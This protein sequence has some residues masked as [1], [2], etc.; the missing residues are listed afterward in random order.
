MAKRST[1]PA[2]D[3]SIPL[4]AP[5]EEPVAVHPITTLD[6]VIGQTNALKNLRT[7]MH[8]GRIHH[9][10]IFHGPAGVGKFTTAVAFAAAILDPTTSPDLSGNLGPED[11]SHVQRLVRAG[12]HP[13]LHVVRKELAGISRNPQVRD[14]KQSGIAKDVVEEFLTEPA[15]RSRVMPGDSRAAKVFVIDEAELLSPISQNTLLKT[16]EEPPPGT[17]IILITSAEERLLPTIRSRAQRV[18]FTPLEEPEMMK[19]LS[20]R[21]GDA[22]I[23]AVEPE[24]RSWLLR[25][26]C[27]SPGAAEIA[28]AND[29]YAWDAALRDSFKLIEQGRFPMSMGETLAKLIDER[30][31]AWVKQNPDASKDAANKAWAR[32]MFGFIAEDVRA[33]LRLRAAGKS[34][35]QVETDPACLRLLNA[36][37]AIAAAEGHLALNVN[38]ALLL[39]NLVAQM[40]AE[41]IGV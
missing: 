37:D 26:A 29:L 7:A 1:K 14:G 8:S 16:L 22:G 40:S 11:G 20:R 25:F 31:A 18:S 41:P 24:K 12:T 9:A 6:R 13:D 30:A 3:E 15:A 33:R 19:W 27:G 5:P 17:I 4:S 23:G 35:E 28:I 32:R 39:E 38:M 36:I 10:W 2:L 21:G 34:A